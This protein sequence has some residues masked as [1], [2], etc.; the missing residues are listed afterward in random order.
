MQNSGGARA[1][2]NA[3]LQK[4]LMKQADAIISAAAAAYGQGKFAETEALCREILKALPDHVD[5]LHLLG[6]CAHDGRRLEEARELLERVIALDPRLHDA[7]NNLATVHFDL[8]NFEEA[9]RC[10][11]RAIALKP[12]FVVALTNL[13][14]TLMHLGQ[15]EQA[16]EL[17]ERAIKIKPDYADAFCNR[18]MVEIVL[19]QITRAKESFDR[20]L[21]FQPRHAE[22][23]VGSSMVCMELR[24][25]EEAAAKL[26][27]ALAIKPGSPRILA[28][29]GRLSYELQRLE[30][31]LADFEAALAISPKLELALR[32]K[33]Q[34]CL[35]MGKTAQAMAA[36]TALIEQNPRSEVGLALM[37]FSHSNQGEMDAAIEYLDRALAIRPDYGD[38]IRGK[39]F[40]QDYRAEADFA[41]QQAVRRDWWDLIGSKLPRRTLPKRPLDPDK[42]IVVGYVAAEFR[43][44]SAGLTLLPVL[45]HHDHAN[46]KIICYYSW[47]G[48][49]EYTAM[50]KSLADVWVDAW[51]LSDDELVDRI[52]AD[53]VDILIDVS[54]HTTG[55]RLQVFARKP[56]PIQATGFGHATGTGMQT[57][58]YVL[59]D[60]VF[61]PPSVRHLFPEK[62]HDLPC[63]ITMEPVSDLQ[64]SELPML[65]NGYVTFGVFNR[66][67]KIS[68]DAIRVWSRIMREVPGSKIV[69]KHG[70]L[71]D[72]LLRDSLIARFVAQ[73][74]AEENITCLGTTSRNDHLM[75]FDK[76]DISLDTFPQNGGISTWE[77]LYKGVPVV[78]K[79]GIGASSRAGASIV[80]AVG[81]GDWVAEDDDGYVE[82][83]RKFASQ[84]DYLA[85][86][87]AG[88]PAQIAASPAGN[89]EIYT[90]ELEAGYRQFW[91]DYC[92]AAS[93][94]GDAAV[95]GTDAPSGS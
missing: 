59:A 75:A 19:G 8:G 74:I 42:Q 16:L 72:P 45:R 70:L 88:L 55:N 11:E 9:R 83:A 81:L 29:R 90:R 22:A 17:H 35:V 86:L 76:I 66:I 84:P 5:A 60:P 31:A 4:K 32:G 13:G 80:A 40:L 61:I 67:Y 18:G 21:L 87:R 73:G 44:H 28:Q 39:I 58:D 38:A 41:L 3:R 26:A 95:S 77:S 85:K 53:N 36:A 47:P 23:I 49:D 12:N 1:F 54:G 56:A 20:A 24:H 94:S 68:D 79:L 78:A 64:P 71:D 27:T 50:F 65:R 69:L 57:M 51:D 89:V 63:L 91:R 25:H 43:Q 14:N 48:A 62:I 30:P 92:A 34:A 82:I 93:E 10:Q 15:Y 7:H 33:A 46:F 52:Q 6:M 37:G 2:Q